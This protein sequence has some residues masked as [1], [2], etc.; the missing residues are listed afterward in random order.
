MN[1][2]I[3]L[4]VFGLVMIVFGILMFLD[5]ISLIVDLEHLRI[6]AIMFIVLLIYHFSVLTIG[7]VS[8]M[9]CKKKE[10]KKKWMRLN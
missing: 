8:E 4:I 6:V 2:N 1:K 7:V 3:I 10:T 9:I 5:F